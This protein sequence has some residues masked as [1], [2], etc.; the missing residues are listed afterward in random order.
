MDDVAGF[1][2]ARKQLSFPSWNVADVMSGLAG[3]Y[4]GAFSAAPLRARVMS[5][6]TFTLPVQQLRAFSS[7][8]FSFEGAQAGGQLIELRGENG[9]AVA[10]AGLRVA[11]VRVE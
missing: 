4:P 5:F 9:A 6:G 2:P 10:P 1:T 11:V 3:T 8:Y 7:S